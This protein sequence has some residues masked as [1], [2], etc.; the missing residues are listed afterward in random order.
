MVLL[1]TWLWK[2]LL[3]VPVFS[4]SGYVPRSGIAGSFG[5]SMFNF[6]RNQH[7]V[8]HSS[9][10][11][12]FY[13]SYIIIVVLVLTLMWSLHYSAICLLSVQFSCS[14]MSDS[15]QPHES[16]HARPPY[17]QLPEFTQT[18]VYRVSD[19]IQPSHPL[20]AFREPYYFGEL[21]TGWFVSIVIHN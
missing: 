15:L 11:C 13:I 8:F 20:W 10:L 9:S 1:W 6:S 21:G 4:P 3:G 5:I 17:H 7:T 16:Q 18:H 2:N 12:I 14:V 19:A